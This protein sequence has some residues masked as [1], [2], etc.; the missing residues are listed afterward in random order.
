MEFANLFPIEHGV[1]TCSFIDVNIL[2]FQD[3]GNFFHGWEGEEVVVLL[4][5][6]HEQRDGAWSFIVCWE[7]GK[8]VVYFLVIFGSEIEG[9]GVSVFVWISMSYVYIWKSVGL[10]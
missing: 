2:D 1:E 10:G 7:F 4:L 5:G 9:H 8:N 6:K 3:F